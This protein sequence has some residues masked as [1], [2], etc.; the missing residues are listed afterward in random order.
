MA[1]SFL[2]CQDHSSTA[3]LS[4]HPHRLSLPAHV[5]EAGLLSPWDWGVAGALNSL[6][7]D[8][9]SAPRQAR[10]EMSVPGGAALPKTTQFLCIGEEGC[11]QPS[12]QSGRI[13]VP[14]INPR[15]QSRGCRVTAPCVSGCENMCACVSDLRSASAPV[16]SLELLCMLH[17]FPGLHLVTRELAPT[18]WRPPGLGLPASFLPIGLECRPGTADKGRE[19]ARQKFVGHLLNR[20]QSGSQ[21]LHRRAAG[22]EMC[23]CHPDSAWECAPPRGRQE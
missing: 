12:A 8:W 11:P 13:N 5:S 23:A 7:R 22:M 9:L 20:K 15:P 10:C 3:K 19:G 16:S 21:N 2:N 4:C 14:S 1:S 18:D 17:H 6:L